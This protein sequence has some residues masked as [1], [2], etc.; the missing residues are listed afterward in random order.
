MFRVTASAFLF[1]LT[2]VPF[3]VSNSFAQSLSI[4]PFPFEKATT[5]SAK[6]P[7]IL[8][9]EPVVIFAKEAEEEILRLEKSNKAP[10][11]NPKPPKIDLN[12]A[13]I[14][15]LPYPGTEQ[16]QAVNET[17]IY[18]M[19]SF[20]A[21]PGESLEDVLR[22]WSQVQG[23][24]FLWKTTRRYDVITAFNSAEQDY[25]FVVERLLEQYK[26]HPIRP[27]GKLHTDTITGIA[28]LTIFND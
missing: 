15:L 13:K 28:T 3:T 8:L 18:S 4:N 20:S 10:Y 14:T 21:K 19:S 23:V 6:P 12:N 22:S 24:G 17:S 27:V 7:E 9:E 1:S 16:A 25:N 11:H 5:L 26:D 2:L